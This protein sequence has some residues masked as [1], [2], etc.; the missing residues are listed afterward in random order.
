MWKP[1]LTQ[2]NLISPWIISGAKDGQAFEAYVRNVLAQEL[3]PRTVVIC[4]NL[5]THYKHA[6]IAVLRD[7]GC[8]FLYL[9]PYSPDLN[10]IE[11]AFSKLKAYL[12]RI[13]A[14]TFDQIFDALNEICELFTPNECWNFFREARSGS[15]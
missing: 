7:I 8:W 15:G 14:S 9:P 10:P 11:I 13:A 6:A 3:Q 2:D 5:A 4:D 1:G 12:R